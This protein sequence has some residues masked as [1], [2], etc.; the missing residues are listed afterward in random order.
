MTEPDIASALKGDVLYHQKILTLIDSFHAGGKERRLLELLKGLTARKVCCELIVMSKVITYPELYDLDI[1]IHF[2]ERKFRQDPTVLPQI[3]KI[4]KEAQP[5]IIQSWSSMTSVYVF[6]IAKWLGI[7]FVNAIIAD[8]PHYVKPFSQPWLRRK[9]TFPFS[10]AIVSNSKA[11]VVSYHAPQKKSHVM[12]NGFDFNR[13]KKIT[14]PEAVRAQLG[15]HTPK[16]VGMV[17]KF[18]ARKDY[19]TYLQAALRLVNERSDVTFVAVGDGELLEASQQMV[20]GQ[21]HGRILFTG[22]REDV[23][24]IVNVF[25]IGVLITN[26]QVHG[27]GISNALME[28]MVLGKPVVATQ[29]GGTAELIL[30]GEVGYVIPPA[31]VEA[32]VDKLRL[33]LNDD[34]LAQRLGS[35]GKERIYEH[36]NL[37]RMTNE[38]I[39]LYE[40]LLA[41]KSI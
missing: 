1:K 19:R 2:V 18:Q 7:P 33:L 21:D 4:V 22:R 5:A 6:T 14:P 27:E 15:I 38:Y 13:I 32:L 37:D 29:G 17:G 35:A 36:F 41:Q 24:S 11:G 31:N 23:E 28:Y 9:L 34:H 39:A 8:A 40:R 25:D 12:Y 30:D 16:V 20:T 10:D 26:H 3:Y